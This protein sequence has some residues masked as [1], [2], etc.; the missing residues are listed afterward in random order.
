MVCAGDGTSCP[1]HGGPCQDPV[2][3]YSHEIS[4]TIQAG[5]YIVIFGHLNQLASGVEVGDTVVPGQLLAT[6]GS[7]NGPH[8]HF[9]IR[10]KK[11]NIGFN[12]YDFFAGAQ[13]QALADAYAAYGYGQISTNDAR[14]GESREARWVVAG[15]RPSGSARLQGWKSGWGPVAR[16]NWGGASSSTDPPGTAAR[17][18]LA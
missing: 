9:E 2:C 1:W 5:D 6:S 7:M 14:A 18:S 10:E 16:W 4:L 13:K 17:A 12:P 8:L 11:T 3:G 15:P